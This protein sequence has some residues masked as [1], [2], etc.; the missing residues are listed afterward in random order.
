MAVIIG[1]GT[2]VNFAGAC[3]ISANWG[4]NPNT[5]RLYCLGSWSPYDEIEKPTETVSLTIYAPGPSYSVPASQACDDVQDYSIS[6][7]P[8]GCGDNVPGG[9]SGNFAINNYSYSKDDAQAPGQES[10]GFTRWTGANAPDYVVRG[11]VEGSATDPVVNTGIVFTGTTS[12]GNSGSVSA[13]GTGKAD[14]TYYGVVSAIGGGTST[15]GETGTGSASITL[16]P[17]WI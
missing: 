16:T 10:W 6:V 1:A 8:A 13:G 11:I 2:T 12:Q 5:Q 15:K 17:L 7:S 14:V 9:I 3:V 4:Y